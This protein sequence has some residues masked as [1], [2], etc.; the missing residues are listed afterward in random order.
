[1]PQEENWCK[2]KRP[3]PWPTSF[4]G[5]LSPCPQEGEGEKGGRRETISFPG[6]LFLPPMLSVGGRETLGTRLEERPRLTLCPL[7][8][9]W[10]IL[11]IPVII[12]TC[13]HTMEGV[14]TGR[15]RHGRTRYGSLEVQTPCP[16]PLCGY[17]F[18]VSY[19]SEEKHFIPLKYPRSLNAWA[20]SAKLII[21]ETRS[22]LYASS[23]ATHSSLINCRST[24]TFSSRLLPSSV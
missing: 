7:F 24:E 8:G 20:S 14:G 10:P 4:P 22:L 11:S 19:K 6:F 1:M 12:Q 3:H 2:V 18:G 16:P 9:C 21:C 17:L 23:P 5:S 13:F 15:T